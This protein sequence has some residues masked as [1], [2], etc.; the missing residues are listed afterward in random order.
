M[1]ELEGFII[2]AVVVGLSILLNRMRNRVSRQYIKQILR[3]LPSDHY[4]VLTNVPLK[5]GTADHVVL[6]VYGVFVIDQQN[7]TGKVTGSLK[8]ENWTQHYK[9]RTKQVPNPLSKTKAQAETIQKHLNLKS[10]HIFPIVAFSNA[11]TINVDKSL[12][13]TYQVVNYDG[14]IDA[15][16][17]KQTPQLSKEAVKKLTEKLN[18]LYVK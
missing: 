12:I 1:F 17:A 13:D 3:H 10:K 18:N 11:T 16:Q 5:E 2:I 8:D 14:V 7:D 6:S 9:K 4:E 15:I